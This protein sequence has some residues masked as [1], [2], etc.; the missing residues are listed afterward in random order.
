MDL[1]IST[2]ICP[3]LALPKIRSGLRRV[4]EPAPR[5]TMP[6]TSVDEDY[7]AILRQHN[8]RLAIDAT[9]GA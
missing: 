9:A 6:E 5:V 4:T 2:L 8:I 1:L 3:E 7:G